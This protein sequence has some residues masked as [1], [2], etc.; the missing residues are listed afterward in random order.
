MKEYRVYIDITIATT[1]YVDANDDVE[2]RK[3]AMEKYN[4][5]PMHYANKVGALVDAGIVDVEEC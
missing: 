2:A 1:I 5:D 3:L 4:K